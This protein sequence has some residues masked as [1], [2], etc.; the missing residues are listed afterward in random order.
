MTEE[1]AGLEER[2]PQDDGRTSLA[3]ALGLAAAIAGGGLWA[4][5]VFMTNMEIGYAAWGVGVLVGIAMTRATQQR[6]QQLA[7][8][9]AIF[10]LLG[11]VAGKAFIY[12]G[13]SG[14]IAEELRED[15]EV[16]RGAVAWQLYAERA[17]DPE[18]LA[19][20][21]RV[22]AGA[23]T[24]SDAAWARML[25]QAEARL[26]AMTD[27]ERALAADAAAQTVMH[28][29][30]MVGGIRAQ[31]SAFD[32]LWVFLAVGTAYRMLAPAKEAELVEVGKA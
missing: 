15:D 16:M 26:A 18:T 20:V 2:A 17:L 13:S 28:S 11:L 32:L 25:E 29:M 21:D 1:F 27:E 9:A 19:E 3:L 14:M 12:A 6:T 7:Y 10:A 4:L 24:L 31:L 5:A 30:G 22:E 23:D 8:I